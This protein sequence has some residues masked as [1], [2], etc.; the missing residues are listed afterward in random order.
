MSHIDSSTSPVQERQRLERICAALVE[1]FEAH[2]E[3]R[4]E[5]RCAIKLDN[6]RGIVIDD[7]DDPG[8]LWRPDAWR[9]IIRSAF[10]SSTRTPTLSGRSASGLDHDR[11]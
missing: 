8:E 10:V 5:D 7:Y 4:D 11:A 3:T 2:P 1:A 9:R 6:R